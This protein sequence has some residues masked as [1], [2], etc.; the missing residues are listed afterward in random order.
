MPSPAETSAAFFRCKPQAQILLPCH[1]GQ[2]PTPGAVK[3]A[4]GMTRFR[5][6][7]RATSTAFDCD[8]LGS[9]RTNCGG[10]P[11]KIRDAAQRNAAHLGANSGLRTSIS[12][13]CWAQYDELPAP[14]R[15][16]H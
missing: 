15:L 13:P 1:D 11:R 14:R 4:N 2:A 16:A 7:L 10:N 9:E 8:L 3:L 5:T 6:V 12:N